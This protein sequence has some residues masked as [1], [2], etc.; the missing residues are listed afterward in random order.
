MI[1]LKGIPI[2]YGIAKAKLSCYKHNEAAVEKRIIDNPQA[3]LAKYESAKLRTI[4][5]LNE[6][7]EKSLK[8][9]TE[10]EADIFLIQQMIL[11]DYFFD[12][13]MQQLIL[14][15]NFNAE[16]AVVKT[17]AKSSQML[18]NISSDY[19]KARS[20][21]I[22]DACDRLLKNLLSLS[23]TDFKMT[24][25]CILYAD[26]FMPSEIINIDKNKVLGLC[27]KFSSKNSHTAILARNMNIPSVMG[28]KGECIDN[29]DGHTAIIDGYDG[30][31][32]IDPDEATVKQMKNKEEQEQ[33]KRGLLRQFIGRRSV[34][35]DRTKVNV[36]ANISSIE[37]LDAVIK[38][39]GEGIGLFRSEFIYCSAENM[40]DEEYQYYCYSQAAKAMKGKRVVIRTI[41]IGADKNVSY[42]NMPKEENPALGLRAI[43]LC[44]ERPNML[45][46]QLKAL[47]RA[48]VFGNLAIML[49]MIVD[50][51]EIYEVKKIA[52]QAKQ[53]LRDEGKEF[54]EN[55]EMGIMIETPAAVMLS[56]ILAKEVDFFSIGTN[57]LEQYTLAIDRQNT[58]VEKYC[59]PHHLA[60][61]RMVKIVC[62]NAKK[63]HKNVCICGELGA[64]LKLTEAFIALGVNSFSVN[65]TYILPL[66]KKIRSLNVSDKKKILKKY[67]VI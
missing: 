45:K 27:T 43:R 42:L 1:K 44:L 49:P 33:F 64:D 6:L 29:F 47:Y 8:I 20:A 35:L 50:V 63:Y 40:P 67:N 2:F 9:L 11:N 18:S 13:S 57:D 52:E 25:K 55:V 17:A 58:N 38:N 62:E 59:K 51:T 66:R 21:D 48:A 53:E 30:N 5:E 31:L 65:S 41:D 24:E 37:D 32:Y 39:D 19:I 16:Y 61:L 56:D 10:N 4:K 3:E 54:K 34:T 46:T 60:I 14:E 36:Y 26:Y 15:K 7:Y 23:D 12:S 28:L 22:K